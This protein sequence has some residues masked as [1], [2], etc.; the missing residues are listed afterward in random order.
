VVD[1]RRT[2]LRLDLVAGHT[3]WA[4]TGLTLTLGDGWR[5]VGVG[6]TAFRGQDDYTHGGR[7]A[8]GRTPD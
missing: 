2:T 7:A 1:T 8:G 4:L 3:P 6:T 5:F